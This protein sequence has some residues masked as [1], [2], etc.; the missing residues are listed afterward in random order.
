MYACNVYIYAYMDG[1]IYIYTF[2]YL[3]PCID[4]NKCLDVFRYWSAHAPSILVFKSEQLNWPV[5]SSPANLFMQL[6]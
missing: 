6:Q 2:M 3:Y 4:K 5:N 1:H